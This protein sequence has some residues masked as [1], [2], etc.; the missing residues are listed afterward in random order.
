MINS[1]LKILKNKLKYFILNLNNYRNT[2][3]RVLNNTKIT[4]KTILA[5]QIKALPYYDKPV[6]IWYELYPG[7]ARLTDIG[8]VVSVHK[9]YFEDALVELKK[10]EDDNYNWIVG[11]IETFGKIDKL[12]PGV[13]IY[14]YPA[15]TLDDIL[16]ILT[17]HKKD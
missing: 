12:N 3:F 8:N 4:Y 5:P 14:I 17:N 16:T 11:S 10:I 1:P 7:S 9:K 15:E 13:Q 2:H 6:F